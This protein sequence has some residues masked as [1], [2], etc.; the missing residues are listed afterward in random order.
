M[1]QLL[2]VQKTFILEKNAFSTKNFLTIL[3]TGWKL[4]KIFDKMTK[5]DSGV[6]VRIDRFQ[7][8][9]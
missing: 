1:V 8:G 9:Q 4:R 2:F 7:S 5:Y 6:L 3:S